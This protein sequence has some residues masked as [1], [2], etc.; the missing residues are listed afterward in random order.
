MT[1]CTGHA[2]VRAKQRGISPLMIELLEQYGA[3]ARA[4]DGASIHYFDKRAMKRLAA[5]LGPQ[6]PAFREDLGVYAVISGDGRVLTV[7]HRQ[8]RIKRDIA[9]HPRS[10]RRVV[11]SGRNT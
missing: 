1:P 9:A 11:K 3:T 6:F 2:S 7:A 8:R 5:H 10:P 4:V